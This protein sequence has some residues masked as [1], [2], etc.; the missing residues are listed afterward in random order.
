MDYSTSGTH[1]AWKIGW[2]WEVNDDLR[3]RANRSKSVRA[4]NIGELYNPS[5][6]TFASLT[7]VCAES[8]IELLNPDYRDQIRSNCAAQGI[9]ENFEPSQEWYGLTRPG[10][11]V[12]NPELEN[13]VAHDITL[14]FVYTP[15]Y[16]PDFSLTVDYLKMRSSQRVSK[17]KAPLRWSFFY[18]G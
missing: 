16:L 10:F 7:D 6:Q 17:A 9:S 4:P 18:I 2:N 13:E 5:G 8:R 1:N 11:N 14:G 3:L 12:G 15:S